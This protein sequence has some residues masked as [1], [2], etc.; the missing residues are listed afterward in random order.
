MA[1]LKI[2]EKL[3]LA[4]DRKGYTVNVKNITSAKKIASRRQIFQGTVL[5]I[6]TT[7]GDLVAY[8]N[9]GEK[10]IDVY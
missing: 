3:D 7:S 8:K 1:E 9:Y 5:T 6:E 2:T 10:W 4:S